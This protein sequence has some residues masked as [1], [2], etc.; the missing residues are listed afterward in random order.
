M[1]KTEPVTVVRRT[2][3]GF[4]TLGNEVYE[5]ETE[6]VDCLVSGSSE[7]SR[8]DGNR[9]EGA[10]VGYS[11]DFPKSYTGDLANCALVVKGVQCEIVGYPTRNTALQ[12]TRWNLRVNV[13]ASNG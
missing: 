8:P 7:L 12:P 9:P 2:R 13:R 1:F 10:I 3:S 11:V 5:T 6:T 4:D